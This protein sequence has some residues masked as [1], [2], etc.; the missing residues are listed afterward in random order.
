[1]MKTI[2]TALLAFAL[3]TGTAQAQNWRDLFE[4]RGTNGVAPFTAPLVEIDPHYDTYQ[5]PRVR[6][7]HLPNICLQNIDTRYGSQRIYN[8]ACLRDD[9]ALAARLP[10]ACRVRLMTR[11]GA[12]DG[13]DPACL[14]DMGFRTSGR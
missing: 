13:Y 5:R 14:R 1:M 11:N 10:E 8:A 6:A 2:A 12:R 3:M 7:R 9:R 4:H